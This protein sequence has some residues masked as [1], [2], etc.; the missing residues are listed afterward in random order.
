MFLGNCED[1]FEH[2][3]FAFKCSI[4]I[5]FF[6]VINIFENYARILSKLNF[7]FS[8]FVSS[9]RRISG[10]K[11]FPSMNFIECYYVKYKDFVAHDISGQRS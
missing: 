2:N 7:Q 10:T 9:L 6:H 11:K 3:F 8:R 1:V 4:L 5:K